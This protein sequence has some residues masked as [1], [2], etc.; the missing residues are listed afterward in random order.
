MRMLLHTRIYSI[1]ANC[2]FTFWT[3]LA[4]KGICHSM[5]INT[6]FGHAQLPQW[7]CGSCGMR[8]LS[9]HNQVH[10]HTQLHQLPVMHV[11]IF[12]LIKNQV[13]QGHCP[14][15]QPGSIFWIVTSY[16]GKSQMTMLITTTTTTTTTTKKKK[17]LGR[18]II[19]L[20][21]YI[22]KLLTSTTCKK[23]FGKAFHE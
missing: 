19:T 3:C 6:S 17:N 15:H 13:D 5:G 22:W 9:I 2:T 23:S 16:Y 10:M 20:N 7:Q 21:N 11:Y 1:S 14:L 18:G 4:T 8:H 12:L